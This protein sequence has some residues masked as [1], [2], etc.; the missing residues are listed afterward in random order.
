MTAKRPLLQA[1]RE[2]LGLT[3]AQFAERLG[4]SQEHV[5][6]LEYGRVNPSTKLLFKISAELSRPPEELFS[7][8][9]QYVQN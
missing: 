7:D 6:S 1:A 9:I 3:R 5:K 4:V 2:E 8:I